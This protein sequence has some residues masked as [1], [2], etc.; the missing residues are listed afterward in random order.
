MIRDAPF[1]EWQESNIPSLLSR[2][3]VVFAEAIRR[4]CENKAEVVAEDEK[5]AGVR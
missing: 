1:F 3:P 4:S 5:E 2:D